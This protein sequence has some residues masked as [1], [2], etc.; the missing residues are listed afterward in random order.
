MGIVSNLSDN[1][2]IIYASFY[3][4]LNGQITRC[5]RVSR[6]LRC[7]HLLATYCEPGY[8]VMPNVLLYLELKLTYYII[9]RNKLNVCIYYTL[10]FCIAFMYNIA[11]DLII[12]NLILY[13]HWLHVLVHFLQLAVYNIVCIYIV[14]SYAYTAIVYI[15]LLLYYFYIQYMQEPLYVRIT[16]D[17]LELF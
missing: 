7:R 3:A 6:T 2:A 14:H 9:Y 13:H 17:E 5:D 12:N 8:T 1:Y 15:I 16:C 10:D 4:L 11:C